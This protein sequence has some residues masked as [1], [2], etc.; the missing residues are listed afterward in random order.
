M[1]LKRDALD[2]VFSDCVRESFDWRC[3]RCGREFP[4]RKGQDVHC[5]H[6]FSRKFNATRWFPDNAACLCAPCHAIVGAD[7]HE[8]STF[9]QRILGPDRY[10]W[11]VRRKQQIVRYRAVDKKAMRSHFRQQLE[12]MLAQRAEGVTGMISFAAY[13]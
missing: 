11:L 1:A 9:F 7:P 4:D 5:S 13:D 6:Y 2:A 10:G 12:S 8:H 3:A